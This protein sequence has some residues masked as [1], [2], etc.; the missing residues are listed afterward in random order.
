MPANVELSP[1]AVEV[2]GALAPFGHSGPHRPPA[3]RH[4]TRLTPSAFEGA[5]RELERRGLVRFE[6]EALW[7]TGD[8]E[9]ASQALFP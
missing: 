9:R 7:T 1:P 3:L 8:G 4:F 5:L 2:L 6:E